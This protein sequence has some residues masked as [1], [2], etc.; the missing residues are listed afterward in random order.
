MDVRT[1]PD[2]SKRKRDLTTDEILKLAALRE[3]KW[4]LEVRCGAY[5]L[6]SEY[7]NAKKCLEQMSY[8]VR[9]KFKKYPIYALMKR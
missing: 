4:C 7:D 8:D 9:D 6:L 5:I 2:Y 1:I 3:E